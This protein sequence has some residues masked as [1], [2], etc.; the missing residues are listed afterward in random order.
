MFTGTVPARTCGK[1]RMTDN[2]RAAFDL[3][4]P[5]HTGEKRALVAWRAGKKKVCQK[6]AQTSS[7]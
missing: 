3:Y 1:P 2:D 7:Y 4:S 6:K 5:A